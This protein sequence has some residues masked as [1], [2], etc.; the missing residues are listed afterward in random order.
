MG[1]RSSSTT[2]IEDIEE[3]K[4]ALKDMVGT[5]VYISVDLEGVFD[6]QALSPRVKAE[7]KQCVFT[8]M[9]TNGPVNFETAQVVDLRAGDD[10]ADYCLE[11]TNLKVMEPY[12]EFASLLDL[13]VLEQDWYTFAPTGKTPVGATGLSE[14]FRMAASGKGKLLVWHE[15]V[16]SAP[17]SHQAMAAF[18]DVA[19]VENATIARQRQAHRASGTKRVNNKPPARRGGKRAKPS[20]ASSSSSS[21]SSSQAEFTEAEIFEE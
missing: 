2:G 13:G 18:R 9:A 1:H 7:L 15:A 11:V 8:A 12:V 16:R 20:A 10:D 14:L 3:L 5:Q 19:A 17:T 6:G 4:G 21:S